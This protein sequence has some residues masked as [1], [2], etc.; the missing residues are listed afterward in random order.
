M[1]R[2]R[3]PEAVARSPLMPT[4]FARSHGPWDRRS[5]AILKERAKRVSREERRAWRSRAEPVF[6]ARSSS[7]AVHSGLQTALQRVPI[8][9]LWEAK[10]RYLGMD[11]PQSTGPEGRTT[12]ATAPSRLDR[13]RSRRAHVQLNYPCRP[14]SSTNKSVRDEHSPPTPRKPC[15]Q[16]AGGVQ[17]GVVDTAPEAALLR[18]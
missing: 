11:G 13:P 16:N 12:N 6:S 5:H 15:P 9:T 18:T 2:S 1:R 10:E 14:T 4:G 7:H 8:P 17:R 3:S